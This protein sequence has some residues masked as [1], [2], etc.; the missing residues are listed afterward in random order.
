MQ[1][2]KD[3]WFLSN[4]KMTI[5]HWSQTRDQ[6]SVATWWYFFSIAGDFVDL[7]FDLRAVIFILGTL[8]ST[9]PV[10][11]IH[12]SWS[13][14]ELAS[15]NLTWSWRCAMQKFFGHLIWCCDL[16]LTI[17]DILSNPSQYT[18]SIGVR[19]YVHM[20][21]VCNLKLWTVHEFGEFQ[22]SPYCCDL[23]LL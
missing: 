17:Q 9:N 2:G 8:P 20:V 6:V 1:I 5:W 16:D 12:L 4:F 14:Y 21:T 7:M 19:T 18:E 10:L 22:V 23:D 15:C 3:F 13:R 11:R